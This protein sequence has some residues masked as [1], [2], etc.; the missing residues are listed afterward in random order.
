[1][2]SGLQEVV[3]RALS[4]IDLLADIDF[5]Q[6]DEVAETV[7]TEIAAQLEAV[8]AYISSMLDDL[9]DGI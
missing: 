3:K 4:N 8:K 1:M 2:K 6:I 5:T 9:L 7:N